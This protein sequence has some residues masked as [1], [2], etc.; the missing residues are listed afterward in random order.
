MSAS[1]VPAVPADSSGRSRAGRS[2]TSAGSAGRTVRSR[3]RLQVVLGL[4]WLVDACLQFQ[5]YMFTRDFVTR[6]VKPAAAGTPGW[7]A[8]PSAE[9]A[10]LMLAHIAVDNTL[11]ALTQVFLAAAICHR[12]LVKVGLAVSFV[13][14][15]GIWWL[16][17]GLGGVTT[18][19]S[20]VAGAPGAAIFYALLAVLLW[21][22]S[23]PP[24]AALG[25]LPARGRPVAGGSA[26]GRS[27]AE[28]SPLGRL[29]SWVVWVV[30][31]AVLALLA[32]QPASR[33]PGALHDTLTALAD[34]EPRWVAA[35]DGHLA[36]AVAGRGTP[37]SIGLAVALAAIALGVL[38]PPPGGRQ[39][40][41]LSSSQR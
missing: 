31:W 14:A 30:L 13:W 10:H 32:V 24:T 8:R 27:V 22:R 34:G 7:V 12:P 41:W 21:P 4:I 2:P 39:S 29:G 5:P 18:G 9:A 38:H 3:R 26:G 40:S 1:A 25:D 15:V 28:R 19:V 33:A 17:E 35:L 23:A 16:A 37:V 11:F 36:A 20:P 6:T